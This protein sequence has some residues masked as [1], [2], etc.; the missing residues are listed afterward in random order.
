MPMASAD[1]S[2]NDVAT[3]S[4]ATALDNTSNV[5]ATASSATATAGVMKPTSLSAALSTAIN[6]RWNRSYY[7]AE[8]SRYQF[9]IIP[10][11]LSAPT[12]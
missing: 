10:Y 1:H 3:P 2:R 11:S 8:C 7:T 9:N 12:E 6:L 4:A 5:V